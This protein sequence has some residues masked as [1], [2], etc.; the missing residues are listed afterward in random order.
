MQTDNRNLIL[1][2]VALPVLLGAL[3]GCVGYVDGPPRS[4]VYVPPPPVIVPAP[5][6]VQEEYVYYPSQQVYYSSRSRQYIYQDGRSWVSRPA[7]AHVSVEML[8]RSPSVRVPLQG[9]PS[10][11]HATIVQQYP[12]HWTPS[13]G[14][15]GG[16]HDRRD[17]GRNN[18][19]R[20]RD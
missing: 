6:M 18:G 4:A 20:G 2:M 5:V 14:H 9:A 16:H 1:R 8:Y 7:P 10:H 11:H 19:K 3:A 12:R 15:Q 17:D 13:G